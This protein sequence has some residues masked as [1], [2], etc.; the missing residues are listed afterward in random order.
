MTTHNQHTNDG[1]Q[2]CGN[3]A[4]QGQNSELA[5]LIPADLSALDREQLLEVIERIR[6]VVS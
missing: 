5:K 3:L 6:A 1:A 2:T 4:V